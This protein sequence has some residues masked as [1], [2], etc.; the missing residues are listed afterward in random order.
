MSEIVNTPRVSVVV[1]NYNTVDCLR[2][3][4]ASIEAHHETIVVDNASQD[5]SAAMVRAEFPLVRLIANRVNLGFGTANNQGI[6][7]MTGRYALLLNSDAVALPGSIDLVAD[8]LDHHGDVVAV[9]GL[10]R[11][12]S[13]E[14]QR[15][16]ARR[17]TLWAVFCEQTYLENIFPSPY[18]INP[19]GQTR[20][21]EQVMG[22]CLMF[23]PVE[24]FDERFFLYC[25]DTELCHRLRKHGKML[26]VTDAEFTH[27]LGASSAGQRWESVARYNRGK[28]LYFAIHFGPLSQAV[29]WGFN[30]IGAGMRFIAWALLS[31][32]RRQARSKVVLFG[33]VLTAPLKGPQ[34]P[35]RNEG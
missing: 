27:T 25:E 13:G 1:V 34:T 29:C 19:G 17:L 2:S 33:K 21:V 23:R 8:Q 7:I 30:R 35:P 10:L 3:C 24:I 5:G 31:P 9:G 32:F 18:W 4:L 22:A 15:S 20:E 11:Y 14:L 28:E 6:A 26:Y 12:P 16:A